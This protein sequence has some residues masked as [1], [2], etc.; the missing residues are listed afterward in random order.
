MQKLQNNYVKMVISP[1]MKPP[2]NEAAVIGYLQGR[3]WTSPTELGRVLWGKGHHSSSASPVC[4]RLVKEG[5][6]E[7]NT[8]GHY[9]I[10]Q[11]HQ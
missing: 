11:K 3:D 8:K 4:L 9:R 2:S 10:A 5:K 6:L 7:R 1:F